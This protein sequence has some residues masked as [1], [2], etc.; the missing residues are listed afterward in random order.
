MSHSLKWFGSSS[1]I[2]FVAMQFVR[3]AKIHR[4]INESQTIA[5]V[6]RMPAD[7]AAILDRSCGNCH[8]ENTHWRWYSNAAPVS[9]L[10]MADVGMAREAMN[11]SRW[12]NLT[13]AQQ[14]DR[15]KHIYELVRSGDMPPWYYKPLHP[16]G[17]LSQGEVNRICQWTQTE[18]Q[19]LASIPK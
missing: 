4:P 18:Q 6:T 5:A 16:N 12:S 11:F 14:A 2:L 13:P 1:I 15:L 9:W 10:Q 3:P 19:R 7:T 17:W 8:S